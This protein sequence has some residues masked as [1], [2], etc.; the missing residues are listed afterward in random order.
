MNRV[1]AV[2]AAGL[3]LT[4]AAKQPAE[5]P[6]VK[7]AREQRLK[8]IEKEAGSCYAVLGTFAPVFSRRWTTDVN[9][10]TGLPQ[11]EMDA[12][13][14]RFIALTKERLSLSPRANW[15]MD[16]G[17]A[18]LYRSWY[19]KALAAYASATNAFGGI[20]NS[21]EWVHSMYGLANAQYALGQV[22]AA[23]ATLD[24]AATRPYKNIWWTRYEV[25]WWWWLNSARAWIGGGSVT[26]MGLPQHTGAKPFPTPQKA[27]YTE[28]F[29]PLDKVQIRLSGVREDDARVGLLK[30]KLA[31]RGIASETQGWFGSLFGLGEGYP[32]ELALDGD[33]KVDRPEGYTLD[34]AQDGAK[35]AARDLQGVLWGVV[36]FIQC[37]DDAGK[38]VRLCSV[39]DWP[40]CPRRGYLGSGFGF[41][42]VEFLLF[43]KMNSVTDQGDGAPWVVGYYA[44]L[45]VMMIREKVRQMKSFGFEYYASWK[46]FTMDVP[47]AYTWPCTLAMRIEEACKLAA[48]GANIYYPNDDSRFP[49][50]PE[51]KK[52]GLNASDFDAPHIAALY[53]AVKAK[54]P[55]FRM[56]YCPPYY[57]GPDSGASYP[58]DREKY[59][60]SLRLLPPEVDLYWTG[61]QVK[62]YDKKPYQV[63]WFTELT[64]HK[65]TIFQNGAGPHN[66]YGYVADEI[67]WNGWHYPGFFENDIACFHHNGSDYPRLTGLAACLWNPPAYD[68]H[69]DC[70]RGVNQLCGDR[71]FELLAPGVKALSYF[72][73]YKWG[74]LNADILHEDLGDLQA[75]YEVASNAYAKA[76]AKCPLVKRAERYEDGL[77]FARNVIA[78]AKNPPDFLS[79]FQKELG[80]AREKAIAETGFDKA[81]GDLLFLP[82]DMTNPGNTDCTS[83]KTKER[84]FVKIL[85][86]AGT[87]FAAM[88]FSFECDP[89]PP[90]GDYTI[91]LYGMDDEVLSQNTL[92]I[93]LNGQTVVR[94]EKAFPNEEYAQRTF[95]IPFASMKRYNQ[96]T[97]R[98]AERGD[99]FVGPPYIC[100]AYAVLKKTA[101]TK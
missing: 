54:Y 93:V 86:A 38:S 65:P 72:D 34:I 99:N 61:A 41:S 94:A 8:E 58:D 16:L 22:D 88:S 96:V 10:T 14:D 5:D 45:N 35:V 71:A 48:L 13:S 31:V 3:A 76:L 64:G 28:T 25:P 84:R 36:S 60:K 89:F 101:G 91:T 66:L 6:A 1:M 90:T 43:N 79:K 55:D 49:I 59:L 42:D 100:I 83:R 73:K 77:A 74:R 62:G 95:T 75:K 57:W 46:S 78:G 98:N 39:E 20:F 68:R 51:D 85:R 18:Y 40:G 24:Y 67:D 32:V 80:P 17:D 29:R 50:H 56:I 15:M 37:L 2:V 53:K 27:T 52:S 30:T 69:A 19:D 12:I 92:E 33:A 44:P 87:P 21:K 97:I 23:R 70:A 4:A 81:K 11:A 7:K 9:S 47:F 63:K 82:T 26:Q